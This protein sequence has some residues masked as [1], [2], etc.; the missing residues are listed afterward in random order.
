MRNISCIENACE[1]TSSPDSLPEEYGKDRKIAALI[2]LWVPVVLIFGVGDILTTQF[3][4]SLGAAER[5]EII[6]F[7]V[8]GPGGVWAFSIV[9]AAILIPLVMVSISLEGFLRWLVPS[10]FLC[11][12]VCLLAVNLSVI[13]SLL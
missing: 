3:A 12:G 10:F 4:I 6:R 7:L 8:E 5:N 1:S 11:T 9:K 2:F 13:G